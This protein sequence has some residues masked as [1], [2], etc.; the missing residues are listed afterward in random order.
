M[1]VSRCHKAPLWVQSGGEGVSY[2][3]CYVCGC[4]CDAMIERVE[5]VSRN[6]NKTQTFISAA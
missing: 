4:P 1:L 5:N 2:Y 6:D 3:V